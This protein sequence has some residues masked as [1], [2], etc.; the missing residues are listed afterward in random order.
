MRLSTTPEPTMAEKLTTTTT[1]YQIADLCCAEDELRIRRILDDVAGVSAVWVHLVT[2]AVTVTH[3]CPGD[4]VTGAL[5]RGGFSPRPSSRAGEEK[6]FWRRSRRHVLASLSGAFL[7]AGLL[8]DSLRFPQAVLIPVLA[9]SILS[10]G[11]PIVVKGLAAL[12]QRTLDM[13]VLMTV[14]AATAA[15]IGRW[16]E[17]ASVVFLFSIAQLLEFHSMD[18]SG[19]ALRSLMDLSPLV[20]H[21]FSG[22]GRRDV[23]VK[24]VTAGEC[25]SILP[26]ERI[27]LDG[28]VT[29][30]ESSV[31]QAPITGESRPVLK[32]CGDS[33]YAGSLNGRGSLDV[34]VTKA[35][36]KTALASIVHT[37]EDALTSRAPIQQLTERF[38][39]V[40][41][42]AMLILAVL[43]A[44]VPPFILHQEF[45]VWLYR[46]LVLV[47]IACPCA[48]V[49]STPVTI[50]SGLTNASRNGILIKGG[51]FLE[52]ISRVRAVAFDKTGTLTR[53]VPRVTDVIP[54]NELS[55]AEVLRITAALEVKSEHHLAAAVL[56]RASEDDLSMEELVQ[57]DFQ[58]LT[59]RGLRASIGGTTYF[60]GSHALIEEQGICTPRVE[61]IA[62]RLEAEGKT[63]IILGT[64]R[65]SLG[66]IAVTDEIRPDAPRV[67]S[68]LR[69]QGIQRTIMLTGDNRETAHRIAEKTGIDEFS[70]GVLPDEKVERIRQLMARYGSVSMV[71]DGMND[72]PSLAASTVGISMGRTGTDVALETADI[73]L[74]SDDLSRIPYVRAL[75]AKTLA[76]IRQNILIAL[77]TKLVFI[78]L[79][80][81][82]IATLWLA[83]LADDGAAFL[84]IVNGLRA[85]K[86]PARTKSSGLISG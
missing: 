36:D 28:T 67:I 30:G 85:L 61:E 56:K 23:D 6:S 13:N 77:V 16:E 58:S 7:L 41:T 10:G 51:R 8:M 65:E 29:E 12:R 54:L 49:I 55:S 75:S 83:L 17:S 25:I 53:G 40:Y 37:V 33:V 5:R 64:E 35:H 48:L 73:V 42:P 52:E 70:W 24:E 47:V 21:V 72:A 19:R 63:V 11:W 46:A 82:G 2:H 62:R 27:P 9:V 4:V 31:N 26:G 71:G 1:T 3:A 34:E 78:L 86:D 76:I 18:R 60:L 74:M 80:V 20:A 57:R 15:V 39:R 50:M 32:R 44:V 84:V 68:E 38:A 81:S 69:A 43:L 66:I 14:A 79:G 22:S 45:G 59:G